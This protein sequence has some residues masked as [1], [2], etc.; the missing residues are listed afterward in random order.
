MVLQ[1][2]TSSIFFQILH[3]KSWGMLLAGSPHD[4]IIS[5]KW[6]NPRN[7]GP[8]NRVQGLRATADPWEDQS[9]AETVP[10]FTQLHAPCEKYKTNTFGTG[11]RDLMIQSVWVSVTLQDIKWPQGLEATSLQGWK[12]TLLLFSHLRT[13]FYQ[14]KKNYTKSAFYQHKKKEDCEPSWIKG[15]GVS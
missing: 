10:G 8:W 12:R 4:A 13:Y 6:K 11:G 1:V 2:K 15:C 5:R 14:I 3:P 7:M 9:C